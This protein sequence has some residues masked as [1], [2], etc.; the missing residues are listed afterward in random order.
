MSEAARAVTD[1]YPS[2]EKNML[3]MAD[4][5]AVTAGTAEV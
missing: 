4:L 5:T 2:E 1:M 3:Q